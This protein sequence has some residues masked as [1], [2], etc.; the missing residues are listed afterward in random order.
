LFYS[1]AVA[2]NI[3]QQYASF[4]GFMVRNFSQTH[5]W[6]IGEDDLD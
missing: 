6:Q 4:S 5:V 1:G 2:V 3:G